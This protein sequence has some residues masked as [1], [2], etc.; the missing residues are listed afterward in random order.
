ME[1]KKRKEILGEKIVFGSDDGSNDGFFV[2]N[3][4]C[5]AVE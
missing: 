2:Y 3:G 1:L 5:G 4:T